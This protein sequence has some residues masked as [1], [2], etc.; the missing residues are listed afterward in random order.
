M[1][2]SR[3]RRSIIV[4]LLAVWAAGCTA[5][6]GGASAD[7]S[8]PAS[9]APS[10]SPTPLASPAASGGGKYGDETKPSDE[11]GDEYATPAP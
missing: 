9:G 8:E 7:P 5:P 1:K 2:I 4:A 10:A 11:Y 6:A 3:I